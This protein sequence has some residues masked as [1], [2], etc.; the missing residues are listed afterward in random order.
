MD[1]FIL[2]QTFALFLTQN[3]RIYEKILTTL[4]N[5]YLKFVKRLDSI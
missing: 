3:I 1:I 2:M 5:L 4:Q